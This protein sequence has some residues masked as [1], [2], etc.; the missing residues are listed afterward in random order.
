[1]AREAEVG[2]FCCERGAWCCERGAFCCERGRTAWRRGHS[3][4]PAGG[5]LNGRQECLRGC[6]KTRPLTE[7]AYKK[8]QN[9]AKG[10]FL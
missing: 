1:M 4:R 7:R 9:A 2:A 3:V 6:G 10:S 8:P 5:P